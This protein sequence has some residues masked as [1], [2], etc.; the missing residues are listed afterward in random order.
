LS[1]LEEVPARQAWPHEALSFTPWLAQNLD[2]LGDALGIPLTHVESEARVS[3]FAADILAR[4][5]TDDSLVLIENQLEESNHNH[6][7]QI[8]T[9]LAGLSTHTVVW[10]APRFRDP[11]LSA[12]RWLNEHTVEPFAFFAV[13]VKVV[14]IDNSPLAPLF[15][16]LE[17]PNDWD[18]QVQEQARDARTLSDVGEFRRSFWT[19]LVARYPDEREFGAP[20]GDAS[21]WRKPVDGFIVTQYLAQDAVGIFTTRWTRRV[22]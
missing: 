2:Q 6:L 9:Y 7:G 13:E 5:A 4:N 21:H 3:T 15:D 1:R 11:H 14:R 16:V 17:K 19:H 18:R 20:K 10:V 22:L 12:I 8:M